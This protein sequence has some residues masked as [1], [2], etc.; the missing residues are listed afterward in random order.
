MAIQFHNIYRTTYV[1][2]VSRVNNTNKTT[3]LKK[4]KNKNSKRRQVG[5]SL[6]AENLAFLRWLNAI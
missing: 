3:T 4:K 1:K 6:T 2:P 5:K